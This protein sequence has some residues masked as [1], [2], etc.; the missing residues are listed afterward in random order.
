MNKKLL[1]VALLSMIALAACKPQ[2]PA[3][4]AVAPE[5]AAEPAPAPVAIE[6]DAAK[7]AADM[8]FDVKGFAGQFV[9]ML[10]C[11]DCPG[12][13]TR[14]TLNTDGTFTLLETYQDRKEK[15]TPIEGTWTAE[16]NGKRI[17][18]DPNTKA[19]A[20][21]QYEVLSHDEIRLLDQEGK[22][23]EGDL[24]YNL[25]RDAAK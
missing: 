7:S 5:P 4:P 14:I 12:I 22:H 13:D 9:G 1:A 10:P 8:P 17:L 18:L 3:E 19:E 11:A 21:R 2:Q 25:K 16:D 23:I 24:P 6:S 15:T 20:D